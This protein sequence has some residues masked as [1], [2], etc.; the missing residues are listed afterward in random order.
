M[1]STQ[2]KAYKGSQ[3]WLQVLVNDCPELLNWEIAEQSP[4]ATES[5]HWLSPLR[6]DNYREYYDRPFVEQLGISLEKRPLESFWPRSGPRWDGLGKANRSQP[7]LVEAKSYIRELKSSGSGATS[8]KSIEKIACSLKDTQQFIGA[9]QS[10]DWA[11]SSYFQYANRLAHLYL[12]RE[13]NDLPSFLIMLY[14]LN[15]TERGGPSTIA[16]WE[17]AIAKEEKA[18][19]IQPGHKLSEFVVPVYID[20]KLIKG[21]P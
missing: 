18:L 7:L 9:Y 5:I 2:G 11:K 17:D 20:V 4:I 15:D 10:V 1:P 13:L 3:K 6:E 14:F 12:L 21:Q 8:Q 19:G 16:E